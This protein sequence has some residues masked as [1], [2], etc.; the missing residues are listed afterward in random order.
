[1]FS[2]IYHHN[3]KQIFGEFDT[4]VNSGLGGVFWIPF[5]HFWGRLPVL[6]W[7]ALAGTF[8]TLGCCL[9]E[10]FS[11]YYGMRALMGFTFTA[12]QTVGLAF[13][14]DMFFFHEHVRKIGFWAW[15]HLMAPYATPLLGNFIIS[16]T[17]RWRL[18]F[19]LVF[20]VSAWHLLLIFLFVDETLYRRDIAQEYQPTRGSRISRIV[21]YWQAKNHHGYFMT[22]RSSATRVTKVLFKPVI[23]PVMFY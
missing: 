15:I 12:G 16:G 23:L 7:T 17:E 18:V 9:T 19:W 11:V 5:I 6:F 2:I 3:S 22:F 20:A 1:M 4:D 10:S 13:I 21:G 14:Q 8:F